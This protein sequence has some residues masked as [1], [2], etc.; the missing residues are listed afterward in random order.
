MSIMKIS[1]IASFDTIQPQK[2]WQL[3]GT[4]HGLSASA[5]TSAPSGALTITIFQKI[6]DNSG[7]ANYKDYLVITRN[8]RTSTFWGRFGAKHQAK[9]ISSH[10]VREV[11]GTRANHGYR[12]VGT[13]TLTDAGDVMEALSDLRRVLGDGNGA[14]CSQ[15]TKERALSNIRNAEAARYTPQA[16]YYSNEAFNVLI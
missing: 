3:N 6:G 1:G 8:G 14:V 11:F 7:E 2:G 4:S 15:R 5:H 10:E 12:S 16:P 9:A 13:I